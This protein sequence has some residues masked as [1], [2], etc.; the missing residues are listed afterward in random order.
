MAAHAGDPFRPTNPHDIGDKTEAVFNALFY[1]GNYAAAESLVGEAIAAEPHE[2]M[3]Y[4]IAAALGYLNQDTNELAQQAAMTQQTAEALKAQDPLR[5]HLYSAVGIFMEGAH[6]I[7]TQGI[8]RGTPT[9]LRMLQ[10]VF[11]ELDAA[12]DIDAN[13]PELSLLK[14]FMDLLLAVNLPFANPD[15]AI[16]RLQN[17]NPAFLSHRGIAIGMRDLGR[18]PEALVE[19]DKALAAAPNNPDLLY[20]KAQILFLQQKYDDSLPFYQSALAY[21][22]QLPTST[23]RQITFEACQAEGVDGDVCYERSLTTY[24]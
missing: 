18:Y 14:G 7:Q 11:R 3:N 24:P 5:G 13:D 2:P 10:R 4:A 8:A 23:A 20:L 12:E 15:Q 16:G 21:A 22:D 17:G 1:E 6:A 9:A 19:V